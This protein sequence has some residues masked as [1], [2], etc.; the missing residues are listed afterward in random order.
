[1]KSS[2][3]KKKRKCSTELKG[4]PGWITGRTYIAPGEKCTVGASGCSQYVVFDN[5]T[6]LEYDILVKLRCEGS[7]IRYKLKNAI[8]VRHS[9]TIRVPP[10]GSCPPIEFPL[11]VTGNGIDQ[12]ILVEE[13]EIKPLWRRKHLPSYHSQGETSIRVDAA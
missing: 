8:R 6:D 4:L 13:T 1:M 10:R 2:Q 7:V 11:T 5:P 9:E 3:G 12:V